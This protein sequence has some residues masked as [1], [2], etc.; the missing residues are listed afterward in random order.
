MPGRVLGNRQVNALLESL[1]DKRLRTSKRSLVM[2]FIK[3]GAGRTG[4]KIRKAKS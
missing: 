2:Q 3:N 4:E 1:V